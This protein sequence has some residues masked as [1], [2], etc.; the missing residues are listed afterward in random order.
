MSGRVLPQKVCRPASDGLR[1]Q[2][3]LDPLL[4]PGGATVVLVVAPAGSGKTTLLAQAAALAT[5]P[6]A[7]YRA[8][9]EDGTESAL[10]QHLAAVLPA[11]SGAAGLHRVLDL[12][13]VWPPGPALLV[14][15]DVHEIAGTAAERALG[16]F[17]DLCPPGL[18]VLLGSRRRPS[19]NLPRLQLARTLLEVDADDLRFR[20][21]EVEH[22]FAD[23]LAE[24]LPP[25]AA[26]ALA[27][28]TG[29]W[30]AGLRLFHLSTAGR[31]TAQ[32]RAAVDAL[33][34]RTRLIRSYLAE[35]VLA[36]MPAERRFFLTRTCTLGVLS[37]PLCDELLGTDTAQGVL[38]DLSDAQVFTST[39]DGGATFHYHQVFQDHLEVA[40]ED[41]VGP[42]GARSWYRR[43]A[44]VLGRAGHVRAALGAHARAQDWAAASRLLQR[45]GARLVEDP[46]PLPEDFLPPRMREHDPWL[47]LAEARH[48]LRRGAVA[49][50]VSAFRHAEAM[51]AEPG[52]EAQCR[53]ERQLAAQWLPSPPPAPARPHEQV[54]PVRH[55]SEQLRDLTR[56][57]PRPPA[58]PGTSHGE[59]LL[60]GV[61]HLL[62]GRLGAATRVLAAVADEAGFESV[63]RVAALIAGDMAAVLRGAPRAV[64][65]EQ[66]LTAGEFAA[67]PWLE[68]QARAVADLSARS[69][70]DAADSAWA[71]LVDRCRCDGDDWGVA[72]LLLWHGALATRTGAGDASRCLEEAAAA[73]RRLHAPVLALW[74][75]TLR[76]VAPARRQVPGAGDLAAS[77]ERTARVL[78][79]PAARRLA[80]A[81]PRAA[82]GP[83]RNR[84]AADG[85][86]A[87][88]RPGGP[89]VRVSLLGGFRL[90]VEG[91][92]ARWPGV[93]PR[94]L[95]LLRLLTL[96]LDSDVHRER[97]V[98]ALWPG[99]APA[100][101][102]RRLQV[103]VSGLRSALG[104]AGLPGHD[105]LVR[106]GEAYRLALPPGTRVDVRELDEQVSAAAAARSLGHRE[107]STGAA[108][109][110][111]TLFRGELLPE[112]GPAD[113][114]LPERER[115][116]R[117]VAGAALGLAEDCARLGLLSEGQAA[118]RRSLELDRYQ[119]R[120]WDL[121]AA[122]YE[123]AGDRAAAAQAR[124]EH[125]AALSEL[126][127][128]AVSRVPQPRARSTVVP[129]GG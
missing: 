91:E 3:L 42:D 98:E 75:D 125:G 96:S 4:R 53:R 45:A 9:P 104:D 81:V 61:S 31:S 49:A 105:L 79:V 121:L 2:R 7:W 18:R 119:D 15:D 65:V 38:H 97:L 88:R 8:G 52:F 21:W 84:P 12:L 86:P 51:L 129:L 41:E 90:R 71:G 40:L 6:V 115:I 92:L 33:G 37:G 1:R 72:L 66:A 95:V 124:W 123:R 110:A 16:R 35:N 108:R 27:R 93:R 76:A 25:E 24:P 106:R 114:V 10:V 36:G 5:V 46:D 29:G 67:H 120:A 69:G 59:R 34:G 50:A 89:D 54:P 47:T 56:A 48:R 85:D 80:G 128:T 127:I 122:L 30:A 103:A 109:R 58:S 11:T 23:V 73:A 20:S 87:R 82:P 100:T 26:A 111:L 28:R 118:A 68:R 77:V 126:R 62:A 39:D 43:S 44:A 13:D 64:H 99:V 102:L 60:A 107:Q 55:W 19:V 32:R 70:S 116:R 22:L 14:V 17:L 83:S 74:A 63:E 101:G 112:D 113:W 117:S 94:V 78:G 57:L